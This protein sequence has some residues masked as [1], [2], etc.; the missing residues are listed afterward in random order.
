MP[1]L[2][3]SPSTVKAAGNKPKIIKEY[4]GRINSKTEA[5]SIAHMTSPSGW[6]ARRQL[7]PA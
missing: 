7:I 1:T 6:V 4:I 2:I 5:A 3:K